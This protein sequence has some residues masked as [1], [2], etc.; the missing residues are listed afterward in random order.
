M[1]GTKITSPL[2]TAKGKLAKSISPDT[3]YD[4]LKAIDDCDVLFICNGDDNGYLGDS[5]KCQIYY[6]YA[7][8]K[9]IAFWR[10]PSENERISFIPSEDWGTIENL[11]K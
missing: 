11:L 7:Q 3:E 2:F 9:T 8:K 10:E 5:T 4:H 6:A 1:K